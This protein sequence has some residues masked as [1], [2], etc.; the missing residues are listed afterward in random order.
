MFERLK[1]YL[2]NT[3]KPTGTMWA[4]ERAYFELRRRYPG[5]EEYA[6]IR[7]TLQSRYPDKPEQVVQLASECRDLEDAIVKALAMDFGYAIAVQARM[8]GLWNAVL[9]A[10]R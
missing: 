9:L 2:K 5:K 10:L 3:G 6:Y 7:L 4:M 8:N 1:A